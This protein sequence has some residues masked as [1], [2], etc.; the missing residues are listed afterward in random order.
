[1]ITLT[2]EEFLHNQVIEECVRIEISKDVLTNQ[3]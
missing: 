1:L 3:L 2:Q